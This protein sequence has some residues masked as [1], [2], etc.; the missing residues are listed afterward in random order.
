L[1]LVVEDDTSIRRMLARTFEAEGYAVEAAPD[2]G[3][4]LA[5]V[6]RR[7]PDLVVLEYLVFLRRDVA[8]E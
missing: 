6:E 7:V 1:I 4:A 8:G 2:G 5:A 3:A